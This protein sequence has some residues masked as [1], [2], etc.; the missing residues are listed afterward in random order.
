MCSAC[1]N[2]YEEPEYEIVLDDDEWWDEEEADE[3][4][5]DA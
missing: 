3:E 1:R 4:I 5:N 2:D